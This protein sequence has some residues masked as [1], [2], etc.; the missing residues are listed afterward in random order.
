MFNPWF[1]LIF[2]TMQLGV[3]AQ[4]VIGLRMMR[5][6]NGGAAAQAEASRMIM[7]KIGAG[8]EMQAVLAAGIAS[9]ENETVLAGKALRVMKRRV[10]ANQRR[11]ARR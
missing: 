7:D 9:G 3:E 11:L 1:P 10:H 4:S 8:I 6:A 2:K 5:F